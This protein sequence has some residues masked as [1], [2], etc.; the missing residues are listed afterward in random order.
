MSAGPAV[1]F[2]G[3][4]V[5]YPGGARALSEVSFSV[6]AG[7]FCVLLGPS[8]SGKSTLLRLVNAMAAPTEGDVRVLGRALDRAGAR[9]VRPRIGVIHQDDALVGRQIVAEA[10]IA[11]ALPAMPAWRGLAGLYPARWKARAMARIAAVGL[12]PALAARRVETLSGGQR[13]RVGAARALMLDPAIV[14]AD[15]PVSSLDPRTGHDLLALLRAE[16]ERGAAVLCSLHQVELARAF[17]TRV[18]AL[19]QGRVAYDGPPSGLGA[20]TLALI[21]DSQA[22]APAVTRAAS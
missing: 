21:Y 8:G 19:R 4:G 17:A 16:A 12:D 20:A 7:E 6:A 5:A 10:V 18:V 14:L 11:G 13:Q 3:V 9:R 2:Q 1:A 15:E 22:E